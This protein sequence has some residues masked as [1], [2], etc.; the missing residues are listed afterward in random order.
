MIDD[1]LLDELD[2]RPLGPFAKGW[3]LDDRYSSPAEVRSLRPRLAE[4]G[5]VTPYAIL[6]DEAFTHNLALMARFCEDRQVVLAPHGK[7]TMA[8]RLFARQLAAGAWGITVATPHQL[9][10][11]RRIGVDH[12]LLANQLTDPQALI[13][14]A[15]ELDR[16]RAEGRVGVRVLSY[17]D[18]P[19]AVDRA[20]RQI[21]EAGL[22]GPLDVLIE[23]GHVGGR[24]GCRG[25]E[26]ASEVAERVVASPVHRLV[27][28]AGY[29]GT[30]G[31][32]TDGPTMA[33]VTAYL[34]ELVEVYRLLRDEGWLEVTGG[35]DD[36]AVVSAGG[37]IHFDVVADAVAPLRDEDDPLVVLRSGGFA[38]HDDLLYRDTSPFSRGA[39]PTG[40][41]LT[42]ALEVHTRVLSRPE[43]GLV[44]VDCG[45][46]DVPFDAGLP[47]VR[48]LLPE[49]A[50][51]RR[52]PVT[53][54]TLTVWAVNDQHGFVD[55][56]PETALVPGEVLALGISHPCTLFDK[57]R[58]LPVVSNGRIVDAVRTWF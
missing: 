29:E 50:G 25:I 48:A 38:L 39:D 42:A 54:G 13:W 47:V 6:D 55:V 8:P 22:T 17:V 58:V 18:D 1:A 36:R 30:L 45:R 51:G 15:R 27:G 31:A 4:A 14:L 40:I 16:D 41:G 2:E 19:D 52:V 9:A 11:A 21:S 12:I 3:P 37:S 10:T 20:R 26:V 33:R 23:L 57:W 43:P 24:A 49:G 46:R 34:D 7:T 5:L 44:I 28:V 53:P 35:P 32:A 56:A